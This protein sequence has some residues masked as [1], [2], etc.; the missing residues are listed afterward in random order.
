MASRNLSWVSVDMGIHTSLSLL[1]R[2]GREDTN[3][4]EEEAGI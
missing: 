2:A 4:E 3:V 1:K